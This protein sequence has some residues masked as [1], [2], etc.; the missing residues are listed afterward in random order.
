MIMLSRVLNWVRSFRIRR[1]ADRQHRADTEQRNA[2]E[3][4]E[5]R[6]KGVLKAKMPPSGGM[7]Y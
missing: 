1:W 7:G 3:R 2:E 4:N 6:E 5:M